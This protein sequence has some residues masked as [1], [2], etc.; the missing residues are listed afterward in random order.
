MGLRDSQDSLGSPSK[1]SPEKKDTDIT[2]ASA[3]EKLR[4]TADLSKAR[5]DC[6]TLKERVREQQVHP[7]CHLMCTASARVIAICLIDS[8]R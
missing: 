2:E 6:S 5:E 4:L 3:A 7:P 1:L 8:D